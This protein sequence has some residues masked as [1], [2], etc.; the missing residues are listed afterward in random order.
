MAGH[1]KPA[2]YND[3]HDARGV[4]DGLFGTPLLPQEVGMLPTSVPSG[5]HYRPDNDGLKCL[6]VFVLLPHSLC[7]EKAF[8]SL[9][10]R[11]RGVNGR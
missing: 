11:F 9:R 8:I 4:K 5:L 3:T 2:S 1:A 6:F 10:G 7:Q